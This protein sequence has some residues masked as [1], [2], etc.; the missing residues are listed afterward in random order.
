VTDIDVDTA[1][2][3]WLVIAP[4]CALIAQY[5]WDTAMDLLVPIHPDYLDVMEDD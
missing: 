2:C 5:S 3:V 4:F 1:A